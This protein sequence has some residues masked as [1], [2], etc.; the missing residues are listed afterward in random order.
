MPK[1]SKEN[2]EDD[3]SNRI[4]GGIFNY[5]LL[6]TAG[7]CYCMIDFM[8]EE[9]DEKERDVKKTN[10]DP[11]EVEKIIKQL[12]QRRDAEDTELLKM[13]TPNYDEMEVK[14]LKIET[15]MEIPRQTDFAFDEDK[16]KSSY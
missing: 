13:E 15:P 3:E 14:E 12:P 6:V 9:L 11:K 7:M 1:E 16:K 2:E 8:S 4:F 5:M 10:A